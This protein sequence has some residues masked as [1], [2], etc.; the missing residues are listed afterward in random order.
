MNIQKQCLQFIRD[1]VGSTKLSKQ[2]ER[3]KRNQDFFRGNQYTQDEYNI[4]RSK[5][6]EP[7]TINR[8]RPVVKAMVGMY[9]QNKQSIRVKPRRGGTEVV[10]N[11]LAEL[12]KHTEDNTHADYLY[13]DLI[14]RGCIDTVSYIRAY[15][16]K[17]QNPNGQIMFKVRSI[18]DVD[19][20]PTSIE[21][22]VNESSRFVIDSEWVDQDYIKV[23]YPQKE[24]ILESAFSLSTVD[25]DD[26]N[27]L[28]S[29]MSDNDIQD[30]TEED[31]QE[32]YELK[33]KRRYR[34]RNIF[35][36][37][38]VTGLLVADKQTLLIKVITDKEQ[39]KQIKKAAKGK[40]RFEIKDVPAYILHETIML[41]VEVLEDNISP[42]GEGIS[43]LP[44]FRF[45]PFWDLGYANGLIDD[46]ISLNREEN[47][48]RTQT[49]K[50][51]N[52][53]VNSGWKT[54][55][56]SPAAKNELKN[57]GSVDGVII[58]QTQFGGSVEKI[59]PN[60]LPQGMFV[61][62]Q[63]FEQDIKRVSGLDDATMGYQTN[64][65]ESGRAIGLKQQQN[66]VSAGPV[67][68][69]FYRTL[70]LLGNFV[71]KVI[72]TNNIY[73]DDEIIQ[74]V[75][76]S[77]LLDMKM[78][79]K[80]RNMFIAQTGAELIEP[81]P[82]LPL[83]PEA[84][85]AIRPEHKVQVLQTVQ[86]GI[87]AAQ[88]YAKAYPRLKSE[89]DEVIKQHAILMM[90]QEL[91]N[92]KLGQYGVTVTVSPSAPTERLARFLEMDALQSKYGDLIPP[93]IFIDATD[94]PNKEEIKARVKQQMQAVQQQAQQ[95]AQ[96]QGVAV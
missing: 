77:D 10:A 17:Q 75:G 60:P 25:N 39:I 11:V 79:E 72:Q 30:V 81:A 29:Y 84:M 9:L 43:E 41:G 80:A 57:Y 47:I 69:N 6:V 14:R 58:D 31:E 44:I 48:H 21:Y 53:T 74:T 61:L 90:L 89:Y 26:P 59:E 40:A 13:A 33:K 12:I 45:S 46:V 95:A 24:N 64:G 15:I 62:S 88:E 82:V 16:D 23:K 34:I 91:K 73:T 94:L 66:Q 5:G 19:I 86:Q 55:G 1:A 52:N 78:L 96:M 36:K 51:L 76:E 7:I 54:N 85:M 93:D 8:C 37:E 65:S 32:D 92:D 49:V 67:F 28:I 71:L 38:A 22:E 70:E 83:P 68:D 42:Y 56:G 35:W 20:D 4:Y 18:H 63:Q 87:A 27:G 3:A 50:I 2:R